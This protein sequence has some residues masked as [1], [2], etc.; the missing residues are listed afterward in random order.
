[1]IE[2][3]GNLTS[4]NCVIDGRWACKITDFG[5]IKFKEN[6]DTDVLLEEHNIYDS[7]NIFCLILVSK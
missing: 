7:T 3:H 5:L 2:V 6:Q 1:M 4:S